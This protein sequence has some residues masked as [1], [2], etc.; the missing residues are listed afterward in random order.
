MITLV[1]EPTIICI[2]EQRL[3]QE[4][5]EELVRWLPDDCRVS[6]TQDLTPSNYGEGAPQSD[7]EQIV[8]LS[9]RKCYNSFGCKASP[10]SNREYISHTQRGPNPHSSILYHAKMSFFIGGIS[11]RVSHELVRHYVGADRDEEGSI[12]Q[13]STRF[14]QHSGRYVVPP[15]YLQSAADTER[16]KVA[17]ERAHSAYLEFVNA[18]QPQ[19]TLD[20]KRVLE[21]AAGLLPGQAETSFI[22]TTNPA[23]LSKLIRERT[24]PAADL[25]FQ[26]L[27]TAWKNLC[28]TRWPNLFQE[29][30]TDV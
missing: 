30:R 6:S 15:K 2:A 20:R 22:W 9:G 11:R 7:N 18:E 28:I 23:A 27:A 19:T 5:L 16:F 25:E 24:A 13:E 1:M 14:V 26:R 21:A 3:N 29:F 17:V 12:S 10:R 4:G 8:E